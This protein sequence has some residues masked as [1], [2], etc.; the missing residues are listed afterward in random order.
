MRIATS[1]FVI[2]ILACGG[3]TT[4]IDAG[5]PADAASEATADAATD[6]GA[7]VRV[8]QEGTTCVP[9]Q[10]SCDRVDLCCASAFTC[11]TVS[12][13]W[14]LEGMACLLCQSHPCGG[15]TCQG[16]QM[17]VQ[18]QSGVNGGTTTYE[19]AAY[20]DACAR[21]WTCGCVQQ[22]LPPTC[23][24]APNGCTDSPLPVTLTCMGA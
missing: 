9:G 15:K 13:T 22:N 18:R 10:R 23:T 20:P 21:E 7:C 24:L 17:C 3:S 14:K 8:S 6:A 12:K 19:C 1:L 5:N 2:T 11:N 16:S 4:T